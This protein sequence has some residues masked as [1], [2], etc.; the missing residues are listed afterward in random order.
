MVFA[1][2]R[3]WVNVIEAQLKVQLSI[4]QTVQPIPLS[5]LR[6]VYYIGYDIDF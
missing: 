5:T 6:I 4:F 1:L 2:E 3:Y